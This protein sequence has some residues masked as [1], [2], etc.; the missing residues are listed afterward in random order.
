MNQIIPVIAF[1]TIDDTPHSIAAPSVSELYDSLQRYAKE[2]ED[3]WVEWM[4]ALPEEQAV[5]AALQGDEDILIP[6]ARIGDWDEYIRIERMPMAWVKQLIT[7][8][9]EA[10]QKLAVEFNSIIGHPENPFPENIIDELV[11]DS[12]KL[13]KQERPP[14]TDYEQS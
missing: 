9:V 10:I 8:Y 1:I 2:T 6:D 13:I 5:E 11:E 3:Q 7:P 12:F 4:A 14:L